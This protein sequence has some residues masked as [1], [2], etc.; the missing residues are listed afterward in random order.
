MMEDLLLDH[1][2]EDGQIGPGLQGL[3]H[4]AIKKAH[5]QKEVEDLW[6]R[7]EGARR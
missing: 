6:L 3:V 7:V 2:A 4:Q 1:R 5:L